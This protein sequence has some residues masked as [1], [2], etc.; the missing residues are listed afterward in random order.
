MAE[1]AFPPGG[2][3]RL[4]LAGVGGGVRE[5][6]HPGGVL[7]GLLFVEKEASA[8]G[9]AMGSWQN[10]T[11]ME[12]VPWQGNLWEGLCWESSW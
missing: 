11:G 6:I 2:P 8:P 5:F 12:P 10:L 9:Y 7:R 3:R 4:L 1:Q